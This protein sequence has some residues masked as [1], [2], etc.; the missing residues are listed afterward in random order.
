MKKSTNITRLLLLTAFVAILA[1]PQHANSQSNLMYGSSRNPLMNSANPA[2]FPSHSKVY[3]SLPNA[4]INFTSPLSYNSIFQY[5]S[6]QQKTYINAN[7]I[8]DTLT[9]GSASNYNLF[10]IFLQ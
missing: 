8:I 9:D 5:D 10:S 6:T 2:F 7:S 4:N 1:F 3:I